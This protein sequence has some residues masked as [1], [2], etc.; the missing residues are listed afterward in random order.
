[1]RTTST[2]NK[3]RNFLKYSNRKT[4]TFIR[5]VLQH[6]M[7]IVFMNGL[8]STLETNGLVNMGGPFEWPA[9]STDLSSM[10]FFLWGVLKDMVYKEKPQII[11]DIR[12]VIADKIATATIDMELCQKVCYSVAAQLV[13]CIK[14]NGEQFEQSEWRIWTLL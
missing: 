4:F 3:Q 2:V 10:D 8:T 1:M 11:P 9:R 5:M 13:S 14:H 6:T 7:H 12:R